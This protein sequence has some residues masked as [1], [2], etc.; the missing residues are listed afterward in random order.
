MLAQTS[1]SL[2]PILSGLASG[3]MGGILSIEIRVRRK[4]RL[5][6]RSWYERSIRLAQR[7]TRAAEPQYSAS[8]AVFA[9]NTSA[10]VLGNLSTHIMDAP[11]CVSDDLLEKMDLL[12]MH[13]ESVTRDSQSHA[14]RKPGKI[15][16]SIMEAKDLAQSVEEKA[17]NEK[18][19]VGKLFA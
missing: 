1:S 3:F 10:G 4:N 12:T 13:L 19:K 15:A 11:S 6:E 7:V 9:R 8:E 14:Q 16:D 5:E 17:K 18:S 2:T